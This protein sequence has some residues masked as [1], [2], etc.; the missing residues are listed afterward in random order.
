MSVQFSTQHR[1]EVFLDENVDESIKQE[2]FKPRRHPGRMTP[3]I[4]EAPERL[5]KAVRVV[6]EGKKNNIL[7]NFSY[8]PGCR[9][10]L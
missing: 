2:Q 7:C 10:P 1:P 6:L 4:V 8:Y 5:V 9:L 3:K